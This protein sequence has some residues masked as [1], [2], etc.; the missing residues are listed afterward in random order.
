MGKSFVRKSIIAL[1]V[2]IAVALLAVGANATGKT[3]KAT[4]PKEMTCKQF[5]ELG[6]EV[7][8]R[9]VYWIDGFSRAGDVEEDA[10]VEE[11]ERPIAVVVTECQK[12]PKSTV[13]EIVK[14]YF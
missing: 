12:A 10:D 14:H 3:G 4:K 7:Q 6:T 8:P 1:V 9:V 2:G 13:W 11:F 5:L